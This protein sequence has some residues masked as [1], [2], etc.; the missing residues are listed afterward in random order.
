MSGELA[1]RKVGT[2]VSLRAGDLK[3]CQ[4]RGVRLSSVIQRVVDELRAGNSVVDLSEVAKLEN[5]R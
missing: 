2:S 1:D 5:P 4:D 3:W